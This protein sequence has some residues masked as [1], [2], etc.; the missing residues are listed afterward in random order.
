MA[1][2][3]CAA[4]RYVPF[5]N[6]RAQVQ[7]LYGP[8][9]MP[10]TGGEFL[11]YAGTLYVVL[12]AIY[13]AFAPEPGSAKALHCFRVAMAIARNPAKTFRNGL[14]REDRIAVLSTLLKVFFAPMMTMSLLIFCQGAFTYGAAVFAEGSLRAGLFA[15][16]ERHAFWFFMQM[17]LFV[18]VSIFTFGYLIELPSLHNEI[19][20]VD[21]TILGWSAALACYP[22]FNLITGFLLGSTVSDFPH[23]DSPMVH[24]ALNALSLVLMAIYASASVALGWKASNLTHRGIVDR[25]PYMVVRHPAYVCKN[26]AWWIASLPIIGE[27]FRKSLIAGLWAILSIL[28]WSSLYCLRAITEEDHLRSVDGEYDAYAARVRYRFIPGIV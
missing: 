19:R 20:S 2:L 7:E 4:Y 3:G 9:S 8:I 14:R 15:L 5:D 25:G 10:F 1:A 17:I 16:L 21:P 12:L 22:P 28:A 6:T 11:F 23:F 26:L 13:Y 18:D 27:A 24:V